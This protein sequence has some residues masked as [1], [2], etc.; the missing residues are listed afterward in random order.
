MTLLLP[1]ISEF[2]PGADL[3]GVKRLN[4]G[5]VILRVAYGTSHPDAAFARH[6]QAAAAL[7]YSYT[8]L[9]QYLVAGQDAVAQARE[10][11][12]LVGRLGPHEVAILDLEEGAG[13]QAPRASQWATLV[14]G[15]L[16]GVSWLYSGLAFAEEHGLAPVFAGKRHRWVAGEGSGE[17]SIGRTMR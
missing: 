7:G 11:V 17:P 8:G 5:A 12:R 6:R 1:D 2:Q 15:T 13:N 10:F 16:G 4:G 14:D 3:A 9:Y